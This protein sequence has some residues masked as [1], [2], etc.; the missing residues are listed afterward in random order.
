MRGSGRRLERDNPD[1]RGRD[2]RSVDARISRLRRKLGDGPRSPRIIRTVYG[3]GY[4]FALKP[5]WS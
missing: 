3:A 5:V 1:A 2:D 4:L